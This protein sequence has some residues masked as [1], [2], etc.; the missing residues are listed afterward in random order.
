MNHDLATA[1]ELEAIWGIGRSQLQR[2][3]T[4]GLLR[5]GVHYEVTKHGARR[6]Y[7]SSVRP[8]V[9]DIK[10]LAR[11]GNS[12][13]LRD[14][15]RKEAIGVKRVQFHCDDARKEELTEQLAKAL[16]AVDLEYQRLGDLLMVVHDLEREYW[17]IKWTRANC[18][19][20]CGSGKRPSGEECSF[21]MIPTQYGP[22]GSMVRLEPRPD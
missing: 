14:K 1:G 12:Q 11:R 6:Y 15:L 8:L 2:A 5:Q 3:I 22:A 7:K 9:P 19:F 13:Q 18:K 17:R 16:E 4:R 21:C 10:I 20:C